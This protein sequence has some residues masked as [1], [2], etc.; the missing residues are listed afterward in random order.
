MLIKC[1]EYV[2]SSMKNITWYPLSRFQAAVCWNGFTIHQ[3][4]SCPYLS[5]VFSGVGVGG[6]RLEPV[7]G[8]DGPE[9]DSDLNFPFTSN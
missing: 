3:H 4:Y 8:I 9:H 6:V 5:V 1:L 2:D 7:Q